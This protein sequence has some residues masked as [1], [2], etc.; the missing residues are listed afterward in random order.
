L[1]SHPIVR[2]DKTLLKIFRVVEKDEPSHWAPYEGWLAKN[3]KQAPRWWERGI[4]RFIHSELLLVK[5]P[6]LFVSAH[7]PRR[8]YWADADEAHEAPL[9]G[10]GLVGAS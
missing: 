8:Q 4:D 9:H 3:G 7:L 6:L 1:L 2:E 5:L 10:A